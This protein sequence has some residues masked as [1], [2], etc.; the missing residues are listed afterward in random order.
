LPPFPLDNSHA[1]KSGGTAVL[2]PRSTSRSTPRSAFNPRGRSSSK[3]PIGLRERNCPAATSSATT[4]P[5]RRALRG[6]AVLPPRRTI[7][8]LYELDGSK[9]QGGHAHPTPEETLEVLPRA[10]ARDVN[11]TTSANTT[12]RW[13]MKNAT[14]AAGDGRWQ[15]VRHGRDTVGRS[16]ASKESQPGRV[17]EK[18]ERE[19]APLHGRLVGSWD[20]VRTRA[21]RLRRR[22]RRRRR[23][24]EAALRTSSPR[25]RCLL[26]GRS[27]LDNPAS[28][29][30]PALHDKVHNK[31]L[32]DL[33]FVLEKRWVVARQ[34]NM[35]RSVPSETDPCVHI[36]DPRLRRHIHHPHGHHHQDDMASFITA[37]SPARL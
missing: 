9:G 33:N 29:A 19:P 28:A 7:G 25:Q 1:R 22:R 6:S 23:I 18:A 36:L 27:C 30:S 12:S 5:G 17:L 35:L 26:L 37:S 4:W 32:R 11:C 14:N 34:T 10:T 16:A 24:K 31:P 20:Q 15:H 8:L 3:R 13:E 2:T 21:A